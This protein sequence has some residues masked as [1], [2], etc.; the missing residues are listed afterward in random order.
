MGQVTLPHMS[1]N[2]TPLILLTRPQAVS[3]RFADACR[4]EFGRAFDIA[5]CP[6]M[7]IEATVESLLMDGVD[8]LIFTSEAAVRVFSDLTD[9]RALPAWCVGD[10]TAEAANSV[11]LLARSAQGNADR[12]VDAI[13]ADA[14]KGRWLHLHGRDVRGDVSDRLQMAGIHAEAKEIYAQVDIDNSARIQALIEGRRL[15]I[16]P[17][18][19]PRS[20]QRF[21]DAIGS[22]PPSR[23]AAVAISPATRDALPKGWLHP[24]TVATR[25]DAH[26]MISGITS[27]ISP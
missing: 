2:A 14:P 25:P 22:A 27:L 1:D 8:G 10:R 26:A 18:F 17:L 20:A 4:T 5:I 24:V 15:V 23:L 12:L 19:S 13:T 6:L 11:G 16:A 7:E 9:A 3:E 21:A